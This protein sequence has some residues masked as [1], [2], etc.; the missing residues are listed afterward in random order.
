MGMFSYYNVESIIK[1]TLIQR[2]KF[3][4]CKHVAIHQTGDDCS[5]SLKI[6]FNEKLH[7]TT[8]FTKV[9]K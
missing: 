6:K 5:D 7:K 8:R 4:F 3:L 9:D 2:L 1:P